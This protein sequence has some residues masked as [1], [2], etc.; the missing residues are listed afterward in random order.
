[1]IQPS[2]VPRAMHSVWIKIIIG[3]WMLLVV[4]IYLL[5]FGPPE[6]WFFI[7]RLDLFDLLKAWRSWLEPFFTADYLS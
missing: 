5:L 6:F 1:M 3:I 2:L 7:Q 4:F